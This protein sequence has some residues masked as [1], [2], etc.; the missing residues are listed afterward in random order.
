MREGVDDDSLIAHPAPP[1]TIVVPAHGERSL[2]IPSLP[3]KG[4]GDQ[5]S[6]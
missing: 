5:L 2:V 4:S 6:D 1:S 3:R